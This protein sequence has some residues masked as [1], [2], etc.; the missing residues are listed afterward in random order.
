MG[1]KTLGQLFTEEEGRTSVHRQLDK[2]DQLPQRQDST[3]AQIADLRMFAVKLGMYD[4][5]DL[6]RLLGKGFTKL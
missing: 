3:L 5:D 1:L 6:L 2:L 4:A